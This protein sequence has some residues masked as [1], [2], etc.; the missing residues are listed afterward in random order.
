MSKIDSTTRDVVAKLWKEC[1]TLQS[2]GVSYHNYVTELTFLLFLKM[3][4]ETHQESRIPTGYRWAALATREGEEQLTHYRRMLYELRNP[5]KTTDAI[6]LAIFTDAQTHI[7]LPKDLKALTI[8]IDKLDWF[9]ANKDG[10]GDVYE[11]LLEKTTATTKAKAGQY[12]TPRALID[13]IVRVIKPQAGEVVQD[14]AAGTGGFLIAADR[15]IKDRTDDPRSLAKAEAHFQR[16]DAFVGHEWVPDTHRLC[17]MNLI[18]HE[19]ESAV[20][21]ADTLSSAGQSLGK[22]DVV[23]TNPPFNKMSGTV[24]RIDFSITAAERV[25]PMPFFEHVVRALKPGGRAAIVLPDN[26][27][28]ADGTGAA[29]RTWV[30]DLCDLHTILRLPSGIF[31]A[32]GVK[33]NV[34]FF[35]RGK[36]DRGNTKKIW[37]YDM[38]ANMPGFGKTRPL[39]NEDFLHFET[40]YG[41]D[42]LGKTVRQ[43]LGEGGRFRCFS[44]AQIKE[45]DDNLDITWLRDESADAEDQLTEPDEIAAAM[46]GHLRA[47]LDEI[48]ALSEELEP[49]TTQGAA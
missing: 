14:P 7:R 22:A 26:I 5:N 4:E 9:S 34:L 19:I 37:V 41:D 33:T 29:L 10:L 38:R 46:I 47:A 43:D 49:K 1:K 21:C 28:F 20:E 2:A 12:F 11:G 31:Y 45:R 42:P 8:A 15:Y 3:M 36:T 40:A 6:V 32:Q 24:C 16:N 17:L 27:L 25:G 35:T 13:S 18:L 39:T 30:M 44:R 23:L 48:E